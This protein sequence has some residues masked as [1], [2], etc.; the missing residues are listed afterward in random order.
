MFWMAHELGHAYAPDLI[1]DD[2]ED[3]ADLFAQHLLF[4]PTC[5]RAVYEKLKEKPKNEQWD[6]IIVEAERRNI[7]FYT[8]I[9]SLRHFAEAEGLAE[10][11]FEEEDITNTFITLKENTSTV[12]DYLF[13]GETPTAKQYIKTSEQIFKTPFFKALKKSGHDQP[14]SEHFLTNVMNL[15]LPD[16][17]AIV[18][19]L[20]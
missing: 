19:T 15:P 5:V 18:E 11:L 3:F 16:A 20:G 13:K 2:A 12:A 14:V 4:P 6:L 8:I 10:L 7:S 1:G 17:K 9:K